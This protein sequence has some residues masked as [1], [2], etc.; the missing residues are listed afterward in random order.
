MGGGLALLTCIPEMMRA[1][2]DIPTDL[3]ESQPPQAQRCAVYTRVSMDNA[4]DNKLSSV[5]PLITE[6][7]R[8][9]S[10][11][12]DLFSLPSKAQLIRLLVERVVV[13]PNDILVRISAGAC[14]SSSYFRNQPRQ[15]SCR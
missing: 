13:G 5:Q 4:K 2:S 15:P 11:V 7:L 1:M 10:R 12:S 3:P 8:E 9:T 6:R 14:L